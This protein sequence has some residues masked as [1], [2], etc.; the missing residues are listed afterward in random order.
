MLCNDFCFKNSPF[1]L[2]MTEKIKIK[3][4]KK[5]ICKDTIILHQCTKNHD[6]MLYCSQ[7]MARDRCKFYFSFWAIF[8]PFTP[9]TLLAPISQ[10]GQTH[11]NNLLAIYWQIVWVCLTILWD[12]HLKGK[13]Q[14]K[15]SKFKKM[16]KTPRDIILQISTKNYDHMM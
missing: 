9:L 1:T 12:W 16:K 7:D 10:N 5:K 11:L 15:K 14:P 4:K 2:L 8:G 13:Q 6:H 3:K